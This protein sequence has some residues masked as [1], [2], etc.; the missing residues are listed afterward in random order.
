MPGKVLLKPCYI[1]AADPPAGADHPRQRDGGAGDQPGQGAP[2]H[3]QPRDH[4]LGRGR[5]PAGAQLVL[6]PGPGVPAP[7]HDHQ[8]PPGLQAGSPTPAEGLADVFKSV[9]QVPAGPRLRVRAGRHPPHLTRHSRA[10]PRRGL[11][12]LALQADIARLYGAYYISFPCMEATDPYPIRN[13]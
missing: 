10:R 8:H 1:S 6:H 2:H 3:D 7:D 13:Q 11:A 5:P 12:P 9:L 4:Q